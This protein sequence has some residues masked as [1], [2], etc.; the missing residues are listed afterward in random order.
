MQEGAVLKYSNPVYITGVQIFTVRRRRN[1]PYLTNITGTIHAPFGNNVTVSTR[2]NCSFTTTAF[3][4]VKLT[5][6]LRNLPSIH[7]PRTN[8]LRAGSIYRQSS[9]RFLPFGYGTLKNCKTQSK[10]IFQVKFSYLLP[11]GNTVDFSTRTCDAIDK[12]WMYEFAATYSNLTEC[13]VQ[14]GTYRYY[15]VEIPPKNFPL[16]LP[17]GLKKGDSGNVN[18]K[19]LRNG[20]ELILDLFTKVR[21]Y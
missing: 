9:P 3:S 2:K 7:L 4:G 20:K 18:V 6:S 15:N 10:H 12:P 14:P 13:P 8:R 5:Y 11:S 19:L 1:D 16:P 21:V 17:P